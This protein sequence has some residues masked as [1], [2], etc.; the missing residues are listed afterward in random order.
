MFCQFPGVSLDLCDQ[1][2]P[3]ALECLCGIL[4]RKF[5]PGRQQRHHVLDQTP[6][7]LL[8]HALFG[9]RSTDTDVVKPKV[10]IK[11]RYHLIDIENALRQALVEVEEIAVFSPL[12]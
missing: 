1:R 11:A 2:I 4:I 10:I 12:Q 9:F 8:Q 6:F 7:Q 3:D 5:H